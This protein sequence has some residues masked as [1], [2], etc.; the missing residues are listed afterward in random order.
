MA[1]PHGQLTALQAFNGLKEHFPNMV[2][3]IRSW[4][5]GIRGLNSVKTKI[6]AAQKNH[7]QMDLIQQPLAWQYSALPTD[8]LRHGYQKTFYCC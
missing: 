6:L 4:Y 8:L 5:V 3:N 2:L 7:F 1:A